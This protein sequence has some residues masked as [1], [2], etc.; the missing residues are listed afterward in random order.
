M[1]TVVSVT[2]AV[3]ALHNYLMCGR[4]FGE[5]NHYCPQGYAEGDWRKNDNA[6][7]V[8]NVASHNYS[9]DNRQVREDFKNYFNSEAGSV[10][11]QRERV[12]RTTDPFDNQ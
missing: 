10:E 5:V 1:D 2:K 9:R 11:W 7:N 6:T 8:R 3:V 12:M 4:K